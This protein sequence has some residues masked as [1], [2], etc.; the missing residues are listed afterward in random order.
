MGAARE[1]MEWGGATQNVATPL[2]GVVGVGRGE[3]HP[4]QRIQRVQPLE[5]PY[6]RGNE[7]EVAQQ[8]S[9]PA[10]MIQVTIGR[11]EVR[12]TPPPAPH[13]QP[14]RSGPAVMGLDEYLSQR[15]RG[16]Y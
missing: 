4:Q 16:G 13:S 15:A 3:P 6:N 8:P 9:A 12:A 11:I 2:V 14:R 10:P 1:A 7:H 5:H